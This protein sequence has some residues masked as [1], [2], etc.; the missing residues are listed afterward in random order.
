VCVCVRVRVCISLGTMPSQ[1][2][3]DCA[4]PVDV[5]V[6]IYVGIFPHFLIFLKKNLCAIR[7]C[8]RLRVC[9]WFE[10]KSAREYVC[11]YVCVVCVVCVR[12]CK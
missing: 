7:L 4:A 9:V 5:Y 3:F 6:Y 2:Q 11:V 8:K 12:A 1:L 10:R